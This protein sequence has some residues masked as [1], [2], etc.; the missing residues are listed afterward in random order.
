MKKSKI[1]KRLPEPQ[2]SKEQKADGT[3]VSP[4]I[5]K[6]NVICSQNKIYPFKSE[7]EILIKNASSCDFDK[8]V[9]F[10]MGLFKNVKNFHKWFDE[11]YK[12]KDFSIVV[13]V[14]TGFYIDSSQMRVLYSSILSKPKVV[15]PP[16]KSKTTDT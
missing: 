4:A 10:A 14:G 7:N 16:S 12:S 8:W 11:T 1:E 13:K 5:A 15:I 2:H 3:S 9:K 6:P